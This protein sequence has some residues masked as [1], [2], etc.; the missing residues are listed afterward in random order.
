MNSL[1][2]SLSLRMTI[3][4]LIFL[5]TVPKA[6]KENPKRF[7]SFFTGVWGVPK[8]FKGVKGSGFRVRI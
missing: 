3:P 7:S 1:Y 4:V 2:H 8:R 6:Q 5:I